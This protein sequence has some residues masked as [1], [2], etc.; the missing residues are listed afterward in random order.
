MYK[1]FVFVTVI[2]AGVFLAPV[3]T[4]AALGV[5]PTHVVAVA[6]PP[7]STSG[8]ALRSARLSVP[9]KPAPAAAVAKSEAARTSLPPVQ[10]MIVWPLLALIALGISFS[11]RRMVRRSE[12][13]AR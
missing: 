12:D 4:S 11:V 10:L 3:A 8:A 13:D 9:G 7:A 5:P 1:T 2:V 6:T